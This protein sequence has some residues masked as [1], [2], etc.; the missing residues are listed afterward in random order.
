MVSLLFLISIICLVAA[1][2]YILSLMKPGFYPPKKLLKKRAGALLGT[3]ILLMLAAI[4]LSS[5]K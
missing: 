3:G 5:I 1:V 2:F 4:L